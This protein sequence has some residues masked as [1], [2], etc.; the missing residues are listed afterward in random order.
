MPRRVFFDTYAMIGIYS[1]NASYKR[2]ELEEAVTTRWNLLEFYF[3]I[4][5]NGESQETA[6]QLASKYH[7]VCIEP[8]DRTLYLSG[9]FRLRHRYRDSSGK[10]K[11]VSYADAVGY[12]TSRVERIPFLTGDQ[13][14]K[15]LPNVEFVR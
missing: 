9:E 2:F 12:Q 5:R 10:W 14:F 13:G 7:K 11:R 4:R 6:E 3:Q 15:N 8:S 1:G